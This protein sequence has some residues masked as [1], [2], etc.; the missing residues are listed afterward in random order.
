MIYN[1]D[2]KPAV[3]GI[4]ARLSEHITK[5]TKVIG[6]SLPRPDKL[7]IVILLLI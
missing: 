3:S 7:F 6:I 4:P 2:I 5:Q 1:L